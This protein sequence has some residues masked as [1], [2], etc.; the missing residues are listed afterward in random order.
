MPLA[1]GGL[2]VGHAE[3][4]AEHEADAMA[5]AALSRLVR[6]SETASGRDSSGRHSTTGRRSADLTRTGGG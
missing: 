2:V 1:V 4:R 5:D 3:D 6:R